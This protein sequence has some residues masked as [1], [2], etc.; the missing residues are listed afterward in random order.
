[1]GLFNSYL[2]LRERFG[3]KDWLRS[4][5]I[6]FLGLGLS[7]FIPIIHA[8]ILFPYDQLQRQSGLNYYYLEGVLMVAGVVFL[9]VSTI[10][11]FVDCDKILPFLSTCLFLVWV[12]VMSWQSYVVQLLLKGIELTF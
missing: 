4:R 8:A 12:M 2:S 11:F 6:P 10:S 5:L 3:S 9:A 1:M 7:A